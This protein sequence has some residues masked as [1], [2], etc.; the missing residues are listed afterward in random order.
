MSDFATG[1]TPR[2][3]SPRLLQRVYK[4]IQRLQS[5]QRTGQVYANRFF[6]L[7]R[8]VGNFRFWPNVA[9]RTKQCQHGFGHAPSD[10]ILTITAHLFTEIRHRELSRFLL[11]T[12]STPSP[13]SSVVNPVGRNRFATSLGTSRPLVSLFGVPV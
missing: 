10:R 7:E 12:A 6:T 1:E 13:L 2:E 3:H 8:T 9:L 4:L 5:S 11:F